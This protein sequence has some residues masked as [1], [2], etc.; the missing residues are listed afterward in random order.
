MGVRSGSGMEA[1]SICLPERRKRYQSV[2][3]EKGKGYAC[4][5]REE[6]GE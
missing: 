4:T 6:D 2:K 3:K 5:S 1:E